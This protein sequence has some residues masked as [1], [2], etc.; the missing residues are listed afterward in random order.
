M[1]N[2][3]VFSENAPKPIGPYS[4]AVKSG[5]TLYVSGQIA[6]DP[7]VGKLITGTVAD[8]ANQVIRNLGEVLSAAGM[9]AKNVVKATIYVTDLDDFGKI[10]EIYGAFFNDQPPAREIAQ[11]KRLPLNA[12]L[13]LS[14]IAV[15]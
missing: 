3:I 11:V 14:V 5:N 10:N 9:S 6:I 1:S 8:E 13:M 2:K 12:Q 4:Q 15:E 7:L